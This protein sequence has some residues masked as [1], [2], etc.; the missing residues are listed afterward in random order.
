L[1]GRAASAVCQAVTVGV[2]TSRSN[3]SG[4]VILG[5]ALGQ[6]FLATDSLIHSITVWRVA[7]Q[8]T[9]AIGMHLY[10]TETDALD[11]PIRTAIV[12]NGPTLVAPDGDGQ[13]HIK[14]EF[15]FEPPLVLPS[16]GT[17]FIAVQADP[18]Y[19]YFDVPSD[20]SDDYAYG[21]MWH[22][23]R[24]EC[25]YLGSIRS[26]PASID[27][28]FNVTFCEPPVPTLRST[29]GRMKVLYR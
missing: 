26:L 27:M 10:L 9:D 24:S 28:I 1:P 7:S 20:T 22:T 15:V 2:D 6:T 4:G 14:H 13:H 21:R 11:R 12:Q 18:C 19:G 8:P 17:Y 3:Q 23:G 5:E 29:W 25:G 16:R